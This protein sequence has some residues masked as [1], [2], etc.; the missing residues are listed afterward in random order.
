MKNKMRMIKAT[1]GVRCVSCFMGLPPTFLASL[2][3][4][5]LFDNPVIRLVKEFCCN[6][7]RRKILRI[8]GLIWY[9]LFDLILCALLV[10]RGNGH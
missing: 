3:S 5:N 6:L 8:A 7:Q 2:A 10:H 9:A 1:I 4:L